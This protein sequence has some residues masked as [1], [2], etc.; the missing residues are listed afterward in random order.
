MIKKADGISNAD[1]CIEM[2]KVKVPGAL[3]AIAT[4]IEDKIMDVSVGYPE[5]SI[6]V[7]KKMVAAELA[8]MGFK[9]SQVRVLEPMKDGFVCQALLNT[10]EGKVAID[11]PIEMN[12]VAPLLP[13]VFACG[14]QIADFNS[15]SLKMLTM[16]KVATESKVNRDCQ[17]YSMDVYQL[18]DVIIRAASAGDFATCDE[19]LEVIAETTNPETYRDAVADY[20]RVLIGVSKTQETLKQAYDDSDQFMKTSTSMYPIHKRLGRPAH[21]LVRDENGEYHLKS[22]YYARKN[23]ETAGAFFSN[24]KVLVGE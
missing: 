3:K 12:G 4:E 14:D 11:V 19:A 15:A 7:A 20:Q 23:Q 8:S 10:A 22:T 13:S 17:F 2:P 9:G 16:K 24:A 21:E 5:K 18:K 1:T 6:S